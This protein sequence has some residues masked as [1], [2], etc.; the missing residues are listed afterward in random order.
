MISVRDIVSKVELFLRKVL[1]ECGFD[2]LVIS[3]D[4][5]FFYRG[6][7][8]LYYADALALVEA[9]PEVFDSN[10]S[11]WEKMFKSAICKAVD[12]ARDAF[13]KKSPD[14]LVCIEK[15]YS[16]VLFSPRGTWEE[17]DIEEKA[18]LFEVLKETL[19]EVW[20]GMCSWCFVK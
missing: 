16:Q 2:S 18:D 12:D 7:Q 17:D 4:G 14:A 15:D 8:Y 9:Y 3:R 10:F 6:E 13:F 1:E 19:D 20:E 5:Y 11:A